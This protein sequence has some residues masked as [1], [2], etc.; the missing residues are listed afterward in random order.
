MYGWNVAH[1]DS[2]GCNLILSHFHLI[3]EFLYTNCHIH[4]C[5]IFDS[6]TVHEMIRLFGSTNYLPCSCFYVELYC[7]IVYVYLCWHTC[8]VMSYKIYHYS[9]LQVQF[10]YIRLKEY[11]HVHGYMQL[12]LS[13]WI[14]YNVILV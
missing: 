1:S 2:N 5:V 6:A 8:T 4:V 12:F 7:K 10:N 13:L 9:F 11:V 14:C 3:D